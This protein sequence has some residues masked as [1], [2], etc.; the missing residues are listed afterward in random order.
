MKTLTIDRI[1]VPSIDTTAARGTAIRTGMFFAGAFFGNGLTKFGKSRIRL[2]IHHSE[3]GTAV[4]SVSPLGIVL[5]LVQQL[6]FIRL[7]LARL[8]LTCP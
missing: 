6:P 3:S 8:R 2:Q 7:Q 5:Q 1:I 4:L